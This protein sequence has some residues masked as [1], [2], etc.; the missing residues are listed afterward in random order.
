MEKSHVYNYTQSDFGKFGTSFHVPIGSVGNGF[1]L[2]G[3][4]SS[5][6]YVV[7]SYDSYVFLVVKQIH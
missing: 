1:Q 5:G 6:Y 2:L 3:L 7:D 4:K